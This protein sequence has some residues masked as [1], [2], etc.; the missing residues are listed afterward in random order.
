MHRVQSELLYCLSVIYSFM[1][2][3]QNTTPRQFIKKRNWGVKEISQWVKVF[4]L[5]ALWWFEYA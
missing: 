2:Y 3:R 5:K 4:P 1:P